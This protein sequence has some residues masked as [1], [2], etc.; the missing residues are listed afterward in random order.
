MLKANERL[1]KLA[2]ARVDFSARGML[3]GSCLVQA[4]KNIIGDN[5]DP[6]DE[7]TDNSETDSDVSSDIES[8]HSN[9]VNNFGSAHDLDDTNN[10]TGDS[11]PQTP[12]PPPPMSHGGVVEDNECGVVESGPLMNEVRLVSRKGQQS[13]FCVL[14][15]F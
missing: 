4:I 12:C 8:P 1:D 14:H 3:A 6:M 10:N 9:H 2:A 5:G 15:I 7:A 11:R 13:L